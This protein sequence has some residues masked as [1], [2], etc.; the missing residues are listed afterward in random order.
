MKNNLTKNVFR[1]ALF[2]LM[3]CISLKAFP[4]APGISYATPQTYTVGTSIS[5]LSPTNSG[6][7]VTV[8]G[9]AS[10]IAGSGTVGSA[11]GTGTAASFNEPTG[12]VVDAN[13]NIY[14]ADY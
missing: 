10:T 14:V 4:Q 5:S 1:A 9:Q 7:A 11:N 6:G 12:I 13:G 2:V 3:A 8:N